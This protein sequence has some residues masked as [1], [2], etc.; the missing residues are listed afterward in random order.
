MSEICQFVINNRFSHFN[1]LIIAKEMIQTL[2]N[3]KM[4]E[5]NERNFEAQRNQSDGNSNINFKRLKFVIF[6]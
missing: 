5:I 2:C 6:H 3:E 1:Q 4:D